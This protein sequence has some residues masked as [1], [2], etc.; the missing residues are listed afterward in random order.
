[1]FM[2]L[3]FYLQ[4]SDQLS[5]VTL[6]DFITKTY[7]TLKKEESVNMTIF[8]L[9][10]LSGLHNIKEIYSK[11]FPNI[12][13]ETDISSEAQWSTTLCSFAEISYTFNVCNRT[14]HLRQFQSFNIKNSFQFLLKHACVGKFTFIKFQF[15]RKNIWPIWLDPWLFLAIIIY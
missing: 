12:I 5:Y 14:L 15:W 4:L 3:I 8:L 10:T 7:W 1:M 6:Q 13:Y 2:K 9:F 11:Y